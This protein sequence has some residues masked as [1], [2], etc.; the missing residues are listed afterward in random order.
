M[1]IIFLLGVFALFLFILI[2]FLRIPIIIAIRRGLKK[3][4]INV[5]ALL[6]WISLLIGITWIVALVMSLVCQPQHSIKKQ[7]SP[8]DLDELSKLFELMEKGLLSQEEFE[9]AKHRLL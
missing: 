4:D 1:D 5:I 3:S 8:D 9:R 6:S 7:S 2:F